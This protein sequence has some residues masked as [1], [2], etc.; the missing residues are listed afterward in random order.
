MGR[1]DCRSISLFSLTRG[2]YEGERRTLMTERRIAH[3]L[4]NAE[5]A[6]SPPNEA[7]ISA[8]LELG[9]AVDVY[10][11]RRPD[12][13]AYGERVRGLEFPGGYG[14]RSSLRMLLVLSGAG[15]RALSATAEDPFV[16]AVLSAW[17]RRVPFVALLDE[18]HSGSYRG[19]RSDRWKRLAQWAIRTS[20]VCIVNDEARR[21]LARD[22]AARDDEVIVYPGAFR[23]PPDGDRLAERA[24]HC[25]PA[26]ALVLGLSGGLNLTSGFDW[27]LDALDRVPDLHLLVQPV[28]L[29]PLERYLLEAHRHRDRMF[30]EPRRLGWREA[31]QSAVACDI[32]LSV[33]LNPAPQFQNMGIASNRLCMFLCMGVPVIASRQASFEFLE[34]YDCGVLIESGAE[35]PAAIERIRTRLPAMRENALRV[36]REYIRA[37]ER[38][39]ALREA[40]GRAIRA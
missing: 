18:I 11:P 4:L 17:L 31:W 16:P 22:Y 40:I 10:A 6:E 37:P 28:N 20:A 24:R 26:D 13:S 23:C 8:W 19:D 25:I 36:A 35:L 5:L 7:L 32:G 30:I 34:R 21:A 29:S 1:C 15:Y 27:A 14:W 9:F 39:L 38:Y 33:Y 12:V 3:L 2:R